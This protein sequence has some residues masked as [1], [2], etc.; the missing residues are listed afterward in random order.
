MKYFVISDIHGFYDAM[1][2]SLNNEGYEAHEKNHHLYVLGDMFDRGDQSKEVLEYLY[3]A[4]KKGMADILLGNHDVFLIE[5]LEGDYQRAWFNINH[6]GT[7]K[8]LFSLSGLVPKK[9]NLEKIQDV[10]HKR[11]PYLLSWLKSLP[12]YFELGEYIF[13]HGGIDPSKGDWKEMSQDDYVWTREIT[14]DP[15]PNRTVVAGHHRV[16]TIR[17]PGANYRQLFKTNPSAFDILYRSGKILI[18]RFVE[19]S[20]ELNVLVIEA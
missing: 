2:A 7:D 5:F 6:N 9:H 15:I 11:Y 20:N 4:H 13:V 8:T 3:N 14:C 18:D 10:I 17:E 19:I 12:L 1:I 16:A